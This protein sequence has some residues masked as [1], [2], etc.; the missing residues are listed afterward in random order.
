MHTTRT[1]DTAP[2]SRA[3][4]LTALIERRRRSGS[5]AYAVL[6]LIYV[7]TAMMFARVKIFQDGASA[8]W[9]I[10]LLLPVAIV[11]VQWIRPTVLGWAVILL[12]TLLYFAVGASSL[13]R[14]SLRNPPKWEYDPD[15]FVLGSAFLA[16][17]LGVC[18]TL[19]CAGKPKAMQK[20]CSAQ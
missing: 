18:V 10:A 14:G 12:P 2:N 20:A 9:G 19:A 15:G 17:L 16:V 13:I 6:L 1:A 4:L 3:E 11:V 8:V 5:W 7:P